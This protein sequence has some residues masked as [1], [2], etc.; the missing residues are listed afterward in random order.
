MTEPTESASGRH[1]ARVSAGILLSRITGLLRE[2]A[3]AH[4]FGAGTVADAF[5]AA[6]RMP[7]V[8]QNLLGEGTLSAS[9]IPIYASMEERNRTEAARAFA[10]AIFG[11]LFVVAGAIALLGI[12]LAPLLVGL[13]FAGFDPETQALTTR[14]V[15]ILFPMT[16]VLVLSAWCL[17]VLNT[18]RHFFLPYVAPVIWNLSMIGALGLGSW[19]LGADGEALVQVLAWG[20]LAGG[21]LQLLIQLP[22]TLRLVRGLKPRI[23]LAVEGVRDAI[24]NF[25]PVVAARGAVNLGGLLDYTLAGFLAAGAVATLSWAQT[26]Y[27]LPISLFGMAVA[28]SELPELSRAR[29]GAARIEPGSEGARLLAGKVRSGM[30]RVA[31]FLI[32]ATLGYI[33]LGDVVVAGLYQT[34]EFG[35]AEVL[36]TWAILGGYALGMG[37]SA[38]SRLLSSTFYALEDTRTPARLAWLRVILALAVGAALM[39]PFD[40]IE[41]GNGLRLGAMGLALGSAF[42]AWVELAL[43]RRRLGARIGAHALRSGTFLRMLLAGVLAIGAGWG[44]LLLLPPLHPVLVALLV[45]GPLGLIY[46]GATL[47]LGVG[48]PLKEVVRR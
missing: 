23:S 38:V 5:K 48:G 3:I 33:A 25:I 39:F 10:G 1:A 16:A 28:A 17:G 36:V 45:L 34:G 14:L 4:F 8:L 26:L 21:V 41:A 2:R 35:Q 29:A 13:F 18:H 32:P 42:A 30:T 27:I 44:I 9:F 43:L 24:H 7:N 15:R 20:A 46:F 6:L 12:A 19:F 11:L 31:Y 37:A 40:R 22:S 47:L